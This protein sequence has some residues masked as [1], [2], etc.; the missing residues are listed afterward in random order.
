MHSRSIAGT[1]R[2]IPATSRKNTGGI[3]PRTASSALRPPSTSN[4]ARKTRCRRPFN[5]VIKAGP[6]TPVMGDL[7]QEANAQSHIP[8]HHRSKQRVDRRLR[9]RRAALHR[10]IDVNQVSPPG[11]EKQLLKLAL[12]ALRISHQAHAS[13]TAPH[14]Q[15]YGIQPNLQ[16][17]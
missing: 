12:A 16:P 2:T 7:V 9:S 11:I 6:G 15:P 4:R 13:G 10:H 1:S 8:L 17:A 14:P 5:A 3:K